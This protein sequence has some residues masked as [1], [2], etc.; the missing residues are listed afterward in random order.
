MVWNASDSIDNLNNKRKKNILRLCEISFSRVF[1]LLPGISCIVDLPTQRIKCVNRSFYH[2]TNYSP[3]EIIGKKIISLISPVENL[4]EINEIINS[5]VTVKSLEIRF[6]TKF[7][8]ERLGIVSS[9]PVYFKGQYCLMYSVQ[10]ITE[11]SKTQEETERLRQI[12]LVGEMAL[13]IGHEIRNPLTTVRGFLQ[14]FK[15]RPDY[16]EDR[17]YFNMMIEELDKANAII[18]EY[19]NLASNKVV[20][21][22][23]SNINDL[24]IQL[25]P[26]MKSL[27]QAA[28]KRIQFCLEKIPDLL[29]DN[30]EIRKLILNLVENGLDSMP[31]GK[32]LTIKTYT[33][34]NNVLL[35]IIDQG[36]GIDKSIIDKI[37]LPFFTTKE[38]GTGLGL[39]MCYSIAERHNANLSFKT[40]HNGTAFIVTFKKDIPECVYESG[41]DYNCV[42][43]GVQ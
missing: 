21:T 7:G 25:K 2:I 14:M 3:E 8:E 9:E 15:S 11:I 24:V 16:S 10:D 18:S 39:S 31:R 28:D 41:C 26:I 23:R 34:G 20:N 17:E 12:N 32:I 40:G 43:Q 19:L 5:G 37:A 35:E 22:S 33:K 42:L 27:A 29:L 6:L 1:D 36:C 30:K 4:E 38:K 13:G